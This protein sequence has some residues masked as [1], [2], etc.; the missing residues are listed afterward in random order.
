MNILLI[1]ITVMALAVAYGN[2]QL[3]KTQ[4]EFTDYWYNEYKSI[5]KDYFKLMK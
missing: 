5:K 1:I 3:A 4:K 2:Y